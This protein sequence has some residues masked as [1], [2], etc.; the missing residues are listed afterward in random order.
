VATPADYVGNY[1]LKTSA[2]SIPSGAWTK[3][4]A[5]DPRRVAMYYALTGTIAGEVF[6][7]P[8][9]GESPS[10]SPSGFTAS[11]TALFS[12]IRWPLDAPLP[13]MMWWCYCG[14]GG[15]ITILVLE[16]LQIADPCATTD[17]LPAAIQT[18]TP[19]TPGPAY[20]AP[21]AP[22]PGVSVGTDMGGVPSPP[23]P[24]AVSQAVAEGLGETQQ[25]G[26]S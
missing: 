22:T 24:S 18:V 19:V 2:V 16:V 26:V 4:L 13:S 14:F 3:L 10:F 5:F 21:V 15:P 9:G 20:S 12:T 23:L 6:I 7:W 11:N 17:T 1:Q 8:T 25:G